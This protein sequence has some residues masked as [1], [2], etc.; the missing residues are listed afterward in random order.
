M[1]G[2]AFIV[3]SMASK[4]SKA[5]RVFVCTSCDHQLSK[6]MGRCPQCGEWGSLEERDTRSLG[7]G[8]MG[9]AG[10]AGAGASAGR[11]GGGRG[12]GGLVPGASAQPVTQV[13]PTIAK[14]RPTG[15][16]ELDRVLGGGIVP[17]S[18]VLLAGEPGV[19]KSTLLLEVAAAWA[20]KGHTVLILTAE[21]S[22]GQVRHRAERTGA[23]HD[24]LY[25]AS[26]NDLEN[27]LA[28]VDALNP[29]LIIVDSLQ[30]M[31][32]TGVEGVAGGVAQT[33]AVTSA[34]PR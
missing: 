19:G 15:I 14:H 34:P 28:Q 6:W 33:R 1:S 20:K 25:L 32:A 26:E 12:S 4:S 18:A 9:L 10:V 24:K 7:L 3:V 29:E 22:V 13:D 11:R 30:T 8:A 21:E 31:Q 2:A 17:G 16:G 5:S 23:L 27:G